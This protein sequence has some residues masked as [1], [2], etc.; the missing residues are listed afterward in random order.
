M[1]GSYTTAHTRPEIER[2]L[3]HRRVPRTDNREA[4]IELG[5]TPAYPQLALHAYYGALWT[6]AVDSPQESGPRSRSQPKTLVVERAFHVRARRPAPRFRLRHAGELR[7]AML[8][9]RAY[10]PLSARRFAG[11]P[12]KETKDYS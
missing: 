6:R 7:A 12:R 5:F 4:L 8:P 2:Q 10:F 9:S 3:R 1:T 11:V